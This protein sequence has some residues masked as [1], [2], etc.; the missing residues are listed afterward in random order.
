MEPVICNVQNA[1]AA[2]GGRR[3]AP[4][5]LLIVLSS[6]RWSRQGR[7]LGGSAPGSGGSGSITGVGEEG[8]ETSGRRGARDRR[9][10]RV[11][12][13]RRRRHGAGD[14]QRCRRT[15]GGAAWE[16]GRG[17]GYWRAAWRGRLARTRENAGGAVRETGWGM[18]EQ[19][20]ARHGT[21]ARARDT[22]G[23]REVL[24]SVGE[25][26]GEVVNG[27][28]RET[29]GWCGMGTTA[30]SGLTTVPRGKRE[31]GG[32]IGRKKKCE[33]HVTS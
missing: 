19:Q 5:D 24:T 11:P 26:G 17:M 32:E 13:W 22:G 31:R 33:V 18:G 3:P 21:R 20:V 15:A 23:W 16:T 29:N 30:Q 4:Q 12:H 7:L 1:L 2:V 25:E 28:A 27:A 8:V 14:R 10:A 9:V 6:Q